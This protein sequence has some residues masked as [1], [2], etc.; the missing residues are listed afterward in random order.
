MKKVYFLV[1]NFWL[2]VA[3][4]L[5]IGKVVVGASTGRVA[6]FGVGR[7]IYPAAYLAAEVVCLA[8]GI[9]C[10]YLAWKAPLNP[11]GR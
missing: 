8:G 1:G 9:L 3:L 4:V 5:R 6:F 2:F 7:W 11:D 10:L